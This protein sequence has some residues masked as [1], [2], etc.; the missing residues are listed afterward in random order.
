MNR[1]PRKLSERAPPL[2]QQKSFLIFYLFQTLPDDLRIDYAHLWLAILKANKNE[3]QKISE[4]MNVGSQY[5]LLACVVSMRS[6]DAVSK[7][8]IK[9]K[10]NEH[11]VLLFLE[12]FSLKNI[13]RLEE[14][15]ILLL[16]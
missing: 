13:F 9:T 12:D 4:R 1:S 10:R 11:E 6:W 3:I 14:F 8:I 16:L 15:K 5:G 7:G 2:I